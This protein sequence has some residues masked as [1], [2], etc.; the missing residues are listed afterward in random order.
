MFVKNNHN[1]P[2]NK[3]AEDISDNDVWHVV[4]AF[5]DEHG[6][7]HH[8]LESYNEFIRRQIP[9]II[10]DY[11]I[12][13][14]DINGEQY[15]VEFSNPLLQSPCHREIS[16]EVFDIHPKQCVDRDISYLG[17][18]YVDIEF[19][20]NL[21]LA[22]LYDHI[23]I[24]SIP[25]MV[26]SEL[27]NLTPIALDKEKMAALEEDIHNQGGYF[28]ING[29]EKIIASQQCTAYNKAYV[30][31]NKKTDPK[32]D[33]YTE[34][35]S[36]ATRSSRSTTTQVGI[37]KKNNLINVV[38][39]YIEKSDIPVGVIFRALGVKTER[40]MVRFIGVDPNDEE[41]LN[42]II[43]SL[44]QSYECTTQA[45]ALHYIGRRGKKFMGP[46]AGGA[47]SNEPED[48][49]RKNAISYA[50]HLISSEFLPH[51][52]IGIEFYPKKIVYLGYMVKKLVDVCLGRTPLED[53][54]HYANKRISTAG[55]LLT[56][57][58]YT[59]FAKRLRGEISN[60][61]ERCIRGKNPVNIMSI[62]RSGII[63]TIM[64]KALSDNRWRGRGKV[65]GISQTYDRFNYPAAI[66]NGRKLV[67]TISADGGKI[68][69]PRYLHNSQ[70]G[71]ACPAETPEGKKC[72]LV[73]NLAIG[74]LITTGSEPHEILKLFKT[75]NIIPFNKII[76]KDTEKHLK[77]TKVFVNGDPIGVTKFP[78]NIVGELRLLRRQGCM[79][80]EVSITYNKITKEVYIS[81]EAGRVYRPLFIVEDGELRL[82]K[83]HIEEIE[84]G[85]WDEAPGSR[86][87]K[88]ITGG[89][90][91]LIDKAEEEHPLIINYPSDLE[92]MEEFKRRRVTHCEIHPS[93]ILGVGASLIPFPDHNQSPRN[94]YQAAMGKQAI[95]IPGTNYLYQTKGKFHALNYPQKPLVSTQISK[96][97]GFDELPCGQ[98]AIVAITNYDGYNQ[99]DSII[100]NQCAIDRGFMVATTFLSFNAKVRKDKKEQFEVPEE[101]EC[102]N[103]K[104]NMSKLDPIT[105][106]I[107]EGAKVEKGDVLIGRT[108]RVDST[109]TVHR[110]S[111]RNISIIYDHPWPGTVHLIQ[112]G[113]NGEGY[114]YVRVV[115]AQQRPPIVGD[116]F[117][118]RH[119]QKG[120]VGKTVRSYDLP[121]TKEGIAPEILVNP[122][123]LPSRMTIGMLI[124]TLCGRRVAD[125]SKLHRINIGEVFHLDKAK[126]KKKKT[127]KTD[128]E[129]EMMKH[130][131][132]DKPAP[133]EE[134]KEHNHGDA[135]PFNRSFSLEQIC[136][137][138]KELGIDG[139][140]DEQMT[141]GRTGEQMRGLIFTGVCYYQRLRH[142]VIDKVHA[143]SRGGR[144]R[145]TRQ[146][147]E[148]RSAGGGFRIGY[149]EKDNMFGYGA[150]GFIRDRLMEQSDE[151]RMWFC[152]I[153]GLPALV[154]AGDDSQDI[155]PQRE[156][157]VCE[158]SKVALVRLPYATKLLMQE[159]AGMNTII[160]VVPSPYAVPGDGISITD[161]KKTLGKGKID[162]IK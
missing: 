68:E 132:K 48:E 123:A 76:K 95:G 52:G 49:V 133:R 34:I 83:H 40:D 156:C 51:L 46:R 87:T 10:D 142:M 63:T 124:E 152:C 112:Y 32:Y 2:Y 27:C 37:I 8:Q 151:T 104:G 140:C 5:I 102:S 58:F 60:S 36:R 13:T 69:K 14:V 72:G 97:M 134:Y 61:I 141:N 30:F 43:P 103:F 18:L 135:T 22:K 70:W 99:E 67:I 122:L 57:Q 62:I 98:N 11:R 114:N 108:S 105:G 111:K 119:G 80:F 96:M 1:P 100:L 118:A 90:V 35:R 106:L 85:L 6:F 25:V 75:M 79:N 129:I 120:T 38:V 145:L 56:Q 84:S 29:S 147:R 153:C 143:R 154:I 131:P 24:G 7:L 78:D 115:V 74:C 19:T 93:L 158:T 138:L 12:I 71:S 17:H 86:W 73:T 66:A 162:K 146:P 121:F 4:Q 54:D 45:T 127:S 82:K 9:K 47:S 155:P 39:P 65:A 109:L 3:N 28:I 150:S 161:G 50:Q 130:L 139:F 136:E 41:F 159:L 91:E 160:R 107:I 116:K 21:G 148:G 16:E 42:F 88:L 125:S 81:T 101:G 92:N 77:L 149:M 89:F 64:T 33:F 126:S 55:T 53:R 20:N 59:A 23:H 31:A 128:I 117:A 110:K 44:E 26:M 113:V 144:T 15:Q 157:R 94:T 137:E